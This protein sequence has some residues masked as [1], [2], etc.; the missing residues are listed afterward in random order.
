MGDDT[1]QPIVVENESS[2]T[3]YGVG[4][5]VDDARPPLNQTDV[6]QPDSE[7]QPKNPV[8]NLDGAPEPWVVDYWEDPSNRLANNDI[9]PQIPAPA[10]TALPSLTQQDTMSTQSDNVGYRIP[11]RQ[12]EKDG[13]HHESSG[14]D[15]DQEGVK[16][17]ISRPVLVPAFSSSLHG[18]TTTASPDDAADCISESESEHSTWLFKPSSTAN[19][20]STEA[21]PPPSTES[22]SPRESIMSWND[23]F[24]RRMS[25]PVHIEADFSGSSPVFNSS[26]MPG[27]SPIP[28]SSSMPSPVDST[29]QTTFTSITAPPT[30]SDEPSPEADTSSTRQ[31]GSDGGQTSVSRQKKRPHPEATSSH[32]DDDAPVDKNQVKRKKT[33]ERPDK[34]LACPFY[35][36]DPMRHGRCHGYLLSRISYVKQHL[37]R[38]HLQPFYCPLCNAEF[39][40]NANL[41]D[42]HIRDQA[43]EKRP[44]S[45]RPDGMT[46]MQE[47]KLRSTRA[48]QKQTE[49]EQWYEI[50]EL[51]FPGTERP[52]S[53]YLINS[54]SKDMSSFR[55][56]V[57]NQGR[58]IVQDSLIDSLPSVEE[59]RI[60]SLVNDA[61]RRIFPTW[62]DWKSPAE[63]VSN[64]EF[65]IV[66]INKT[67]DS[68]ES[69]NNNGAGNEMGE[70]ADK[71]LEVHG[72]KGNIETTSNGTQTSPASDKSVRRVSSMSMETPSNTTSCLPNLST[73]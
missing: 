49:E 43:C 59:G 30:E 4:L 52:S 62:W 50:F 15:L 40:T 23:E 36:K 12:Q 28:N 67:E 71:A 39:G 34:A 44:S 35:K 45:E 66:T 3:V 53:P 54:L 33:D 38:H 29:T 17:D 68:K 64:T 5:W 10:R 57:E 26:P 37:F 1:L 7:K 65:T 61:I 41:R 19:S 21:S 9:A 46:P 56:F 31:T 11:I 70:P 63:R 51:L 48:K 58:T 6:E 73:S 60:R 13:L 69:Q 20:P 24:E 72:G 2:V 8:V 18:A 14:S 42:D 32:A 27:S 55:E 16:S 25:P 22:T 47:Q